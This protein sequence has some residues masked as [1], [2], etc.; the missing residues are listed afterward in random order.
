MPESA[1][2]LVF[3]VRMCR[4][5]FTVLDGIPAIITVMTMIAER[6]RKAHVRHALSGALKEDVHGQ[7]EVGLHPAD[8]PQAADNHH[9]AHI[10]PTAAVLI[11][12]HP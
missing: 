11:Q 8:L 12:V 2:P 5:P 1:V 4:S 10:M 7:I 9:E 6:A 3:K